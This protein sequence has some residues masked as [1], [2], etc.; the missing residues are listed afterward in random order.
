MPN[1]N[2]LTLFCVFHD[3]VWVNL[4][5]AFDFN[6]NIIVVFVILCFLKLNGSPGKINDVAD[7]MTEILLFA[8]KSN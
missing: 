7:W 6:F 8:G 4:V 5:E 3:P 1:L 2:A